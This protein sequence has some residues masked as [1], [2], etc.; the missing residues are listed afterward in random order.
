ME[1]KYYDV[2]IVGG[3]PAGYTAAAEAAQHGLTTAVID[4]EEKQIGGCCLNQGCIPMKTLLA[5]ARDVSKQHIAVA[6]AWSIS[7]QRITDSV[8]KMREGIRTLL[9][10]RN[11]EV[12]E[13]QAQIHGVDS[14][15]VAGKEYA[16]GNLILATGSKPYIPDNCRKNKAVLA[17]DNIWTLDKL[18]ASVAIIGAGVIG[19][20]LAAA[21]AEL[22]VK[23]V[24]IDQQEKILSDFEQA[25]V[26]QMMRALT[27]KG[28][29]VCLGETVLEIANGNSEVLCESKDLKTVTQLVYVQGKK[30]TWQVEKVI[31]AA[32][33]VPC[34][35][36]ENAEQLGLKTDER[37]FIQADEQ[38][39]TSKAGIYCIGDGNGQHQLANY[40]M[41][42]A[43]LAIE[44]IIEN[45]KKLQLLKHGITD[46]CK[47]EKS[48]FLIPRIVDTIPPLASLG[49]TEQEAE[50]RGYEIRVGNAPYQVLGAAN[51]QGY[52]I[53]KIVVI[54][55]VQKDVL[56]G[57]HIRGEQAQE[58]IHILRPYLEMEIPG[59]RIQR[60]MYAH[61][62]LA[63]GLQIAVEES[64]DGSSQM[65]WKG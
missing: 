53:G 26:K 25:Q 10:S 15:V 11:V 21:L 40:A 57:V 56:L 62:S 31:Y 32:G 13:G 4:I 2:L 19:C 58:L 43:K 37:G 30:R 35:T 63:E 51:V 65:L 9:A 41:Y 59:S 23:I 36:V 61:P 49:I 1:K 60:E 24:L 42:Q 44:D 45:S 12:I 52:A 55:D 46:A 34:F 3:G 7:S 6:D 64:Y 8:T 5:V 14:I 17:A 16:A 20:E 29:D 38:G 18:P 33:R 54:R 50:K 48:V 47:G 39:K 22:Q 28:V 27:R